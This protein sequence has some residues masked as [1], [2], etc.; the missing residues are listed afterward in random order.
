MPRRVLKG[1]A[2]ERFGHYCRC[3]WA[4]TILL[5][6]SRRWRS[7]LCVA[8]IGLFECHPPHAT[9]ASVPDDAREISISIV[10]RNRLDVMVYV[11]HDGMR[12]RLGLAPA[13]TTTDFNLTLRLFGAG[14]EYRLIADPIGLRIVVTSETLHAVAGDAVTWSLEDSF[15]RSTVVFH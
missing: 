13:S 14:K 2:S 1:K 8:V 9:P 10:N 5:G 4:G 11:V 7:L 15:A 3:S 12:T 6:M